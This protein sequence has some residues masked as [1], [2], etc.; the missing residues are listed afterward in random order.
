MLFNSLEFVIF[1]AVFFLLWP[2]LRRSCHS[3][4]A[5]LTIASFFFYG[6]W[7]WRFLFLILASGLLDFSV[8]LG[9][10]R[11]PN[12]RRL[13]LL[14]SVLGNVGSLAAFK[15]STFIAG[16]IDALM[17]LLGLNTH[18]ASSVPP[19]MAIVPVGISFYT[20]QSMS[21]TIDVYRGKLEPTHDVLH[22]FAYLSMFPQLVAGPIVRASSLLPQLKENRPVTEQ[23][24]W[25]GLRLIASGLFKKMVIADN[26]APHVTAIFENP[27]MSE[28]S[29][30][31]WAAVAMFSVQ[32]YC[33]FSGYSD[34]ARGLARWM[35]YR[36][37]L[38]FNHPY[39]AVSFRDFWSRWHI[40]LSTWFRDYVYIP[41]GGSRNGFLAGLGSMMLTMLI[42]GLWH[43]AS[44][45]FVAWGAVHAVY[46]AFERL[47]GWPKKLMRLPAGNWICLFVVQ[48]QVLLAWVFFRAGSFE[49]ARHIFASMFSFSGALDVPLIQG[50][51]TTYDEAMA[52]LVLAGLFA[53]HELYYFVFGDRVFLPETARRVAGPVVVGL[54]IVAC[55]VLRGPGVAFIYFQF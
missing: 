7:D 47:T 22:F 23:D 33:D 17:G 11:F 34:I 53:L 12:R 24:R 29:A 42:S 14:L 5:W 39:T 55:I 52:C 26:M 4:W 10:G 50:G 27:F 30:I 35:G 41:L 54:M 15:Y 48:L 38:N 40:S 8:G 9:M 43:G 18:M 36:F 28:S 6:W 21:Y 1:A 45:T 3:R 51:F 32:I 13:L 46:L 25:D 49:Q 2:W 44:W 31:W 20:F 16:N 19:F 37:D